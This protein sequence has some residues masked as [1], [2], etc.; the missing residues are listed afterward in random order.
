MKNTKNRYTLIITLIVTILSV[1][2]I[3][4]KE[5]RNS[6]TKEIPVSSPV[7]LEI[8]HM[9]GG[10]TINAYD[11]DEIRIDAVK[12]VDAIS[13]KEAAEL[14]DLIQIKTKENKDR[15]YISTSFT[16][17]RGEK[18]S[19]WKRV[20]GSDDEDRI[21][22]VDL[23]IAVPEKCN[24]RITSAFG[25]ISVADIRGNVKISSSAADIKL[26][27]IIGRIEIKNSAGTTHGE[28]LF[29]E[30]SVRQDVGEI[31]LQFIE[32][33][34]KIRTTSALVTILQERGSIDLQTLS[35]SAFVQ[36]NLEDGN[37][38]Q[39]ESESGSIH[40]IVPAMSSGQFN[41][42]TELGEITTEIP[43][44]IKSLTKTQMIGEFG[45]GGAKVRVSS[46]T[47]DITVAQF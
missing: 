37:K 41:I 9:V 46:V 17:F 27:S 12:R 15:V 26:N 32:G 22:S 40:L 47:G 6:W 3:S 11:G 18:K 34:I 4:A 24:L 36:T 14:F 35:G 10:I 23:I 16:K 30:V 2:G 28:L 33:D 29:G 7:L 8:N 39:I 42:T 5:F 45:Y 20:F 25:D 43:I 44:A 31:D 21:G 19:F 1:S 13:I 38:Y